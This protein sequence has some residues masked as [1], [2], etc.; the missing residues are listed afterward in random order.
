MFSENV[1]PNMTQ[2]DPWDKFRLTL[3]D[4]IDSDNVT[5]RELFQLSQSKTGKVTDGISYFEA[6]DGHFEHKRDAVVEFLIHL[7]TETKL[8][9][10]EGTTSLPSILKEYTEQRRKNDE[11]MK[12]LKIWSKCDLIGREEEIQKAMDSLQNQQSK[13]V[14]IC[15]LGGMGKTSVADE[16]CRRLSGETANWRILKVELREQKHVRD[17]VRSAL[18]LLG[19]LLMTSNREELSDGDLESAS[20]LDEE[21]YFEDINQDSRRHLLIKRCCESS[22]QNKVFL[23]DNM[24][25]ILASNEGDVI[26]FLNKLVNMLIEAEEDEMHQGKT[27]VL[28]T[29]RPSLPSTEKA[30]IL[31]EVFVE[32]KLQELSEQHAITLFKQELTQ[33]NIQCKEEDIKKMASICSYCPLAMLSLSSVL[34]DISPSKLTETFSLCTNSAIQNNIIGIES[35]L[36]QSFSVLDKSGK[37]NKITCTLMQLFVFRTIKFDIE[38]AKFVCGRST[39]SGKASMEWE[40]VYLKRYHFLE[41]SIGTLFKSESNDQIIKE[42]SSQKAYSSKCYYIHPLVYQ[43][44]KSKEA[45]YQ[46]L[47]NNARERYV[48]YIYKTVSKTAKM[49]SAESLRTIAKYEPHFHTF[50]EYVMDLHTNPKPN[51]RDLPSALSVVNTEWLTDLILDTTRRCQYY[52][53]MISNAEE[54][55][56]VLDLVY[57]KTCLAKLY[58]DNERMESCQRIL[59]EI[60]STIIEHEQL[61]KAANYVK[62]KRRV[63]DYPSALILGGFWTMH[64]R[65]L[66]M[67]ENYGEAKQYLEM[68][69]CTTMKKERDC[70]S[71]IANIYN[72]MGVIAF[73][74]KEY[75]T[76]REYHSRALT[77][78]EREHD[79]FIDK[80]I[81]LTNIGSA[82]LKE[83]DQDRLR[84]D[85]LQ[86]AEIYYNTALSM[87]TARAEKRAKILKMRGKLYLLQGKFEASEKDLQESLNIWKQYV[88]PPHINLISSYQDIS[89]LFVQKATHLLKLREPSTEAASFLA[90]ADANYKEIQRQ[91]EQGG[92]FNWQKNKILYDQIKKNHKI[93]LRQL[94]KDQREIEQV[95]GFY[96]DFEAGKLNKKILRNQSMDLDNELS[97]FST[98]QSNEGSDSPSSDSESSF[99]SITSEEEI[100][101]I[102]RCDDRT[103]SFDGCTESVGVTNSDETMNVIST[104][105]PESSLHSGSIDS[106]MG[107]SITSFPSL[108]DSDSKPRLSF[109]PS[110]SME[111]DV[112]SSCEKSVLNHFNFLKKRS[113]SDRHNTCTLKRQKGFDE[114]IQCMGPNNAY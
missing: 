69:L 49:A 4:V 17:L 47:V 75:K 50:Y 84:E 14:W 22:E 44:L 114:N 42:K 5:R 102:K 24:D 110:G 86:E 26:S 37:Q 100:S 97:S 54:D 67:L 2:I 89:S 59:T 80:D 21:D 57:Y 82:F 51:L 18:I 30:R 78:V 25:D 70:W 39:N 46:V 74:S 43:F 53:N 106:G 79:D 36:Q 98:D 94:N 92:F 107:D 12:Q 113:S 35:C 64:A 9:L 96:L 81:F 104:R 99:L 11:K 8:H 52:K 83:W 61:S 13:G 109:I 87:E 31:R 6:L 90:R 93:V 7:T 16:V 66:S 38:A 103:L 3:I 85:A 56:K 77:T 19:E 71:Q 10:D 105:K 40:I 111:E 62:N 95:N 20:K 76:A 72:L 55:D 88:H 33:Q 15:G 68:A 108:T 65:Y 91:I 41:S 28:I 29:S 60:D 32:I 34:K 1:G 63:K 73:K 23:L 45:Q 27:R 58:F 48:E 112:F 101:V